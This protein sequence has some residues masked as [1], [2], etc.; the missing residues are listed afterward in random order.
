MMAI[1]ITILQFCLVGDFLF[2]FMDINLFINV[3]K[4]SAAVLEMVIIFGDVSFVLAK[5]W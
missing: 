5:R 3:E 1:E 2:Y 4:S